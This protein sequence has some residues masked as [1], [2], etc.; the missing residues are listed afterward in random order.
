MVRFP[1]KRIFITN[2]MGIFLTATYSGGEIVSGTMIV[3]VQENGSL[4]FRYN[5]VNIQNEIRGGLVNQ[6]LKYFPMVE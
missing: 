5:H 3:I 6:R 4:D 2:K 1:Q